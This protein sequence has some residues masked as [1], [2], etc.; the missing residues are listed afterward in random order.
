MP[1]SPLVLF[2]M[3]V[4]LVIIAWA[5]REVVTTRRLLREGRARASDREADRATGA[6]DEAPGVPRD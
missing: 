5:V 3:L 6:D 2:E 4:L 1:M